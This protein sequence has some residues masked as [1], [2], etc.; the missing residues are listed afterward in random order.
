MAVLA[1]E[2]I[3]RDKQAAVSCADGYLTVWELDECRMI[4][5][6][7]LR[8]VQVGMRFC[9]IMDVLISWG[10]DDFKHEILVWDVD[11]LKVLHVIDGHSQPVKD[12]CEVA[13]PLHSGLEKNGRSFDPTL[14]N[15]SL[16][17]TAFLKKYTSSTFAWVCLNV[18]VIFFTPSEV[19]LSEISRLKVVVLQ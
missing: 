4:R 9:P 8:D 16:I 11:T 1:A 2:F 18:L 5:H 19:A 10:V 17:T 14:G 13:S 12:V 15:P 7:R 3:G 6:T